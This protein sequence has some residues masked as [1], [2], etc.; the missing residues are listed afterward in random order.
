MIKLYNELRRN[1]TEEAI[2]GTGESTGLANKNPS[3]LPLSV[4]SLLI[5]FTGLVGNGALFILLRFKVKRN[6]FI[7]YVINLTVADFIYLVGL[8]IWMLYMFCSLNGLKSSK[9]VMKHLAQISDL[10]YNFGF[11]TGIY[12]LTVIG[13]ER[14]FAV[15]YPLWYQCHRP[16]NLA[17]YISTALWLLSALVTGLELFIC[18]G[19]K[20]YL[21]QGSENC[22]NVYFFTSA[23]YVIVVLIMLWSSVTLLLD[24]DKAP[25]HCHSPK[26]YI[27]IIAS[28]TIFLVSVVPS[29][30]LGLLLYFNI[31]SEKK[32]LVSIFFITSISSAINC[33]ANPYI[34]IVVSKWGGKKSLKRSLK[35]MLENIFKE[36]TESQTMATTPM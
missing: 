35:Y 27:I 30:I 24:I 3:S 10:F 33:S 1:E 5:C 4:F 17:L 26:L 6:Q 22:T 2:N 16:K 20:H 29:R 15:L 8:S 13:L 31:L 14:C 25:Q 7:L 21:L 23:L 36:P 11:N 28:I 18:D 34:Y 19:E 32:Y 9:I 12:L